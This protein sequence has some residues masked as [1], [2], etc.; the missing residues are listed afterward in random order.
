MNATAHGGKAVL[1][2]L[3]ECGRL[4]TGG[5]PNRGNSDYWGGDVPWIS[6]KS[7]KQFEVTDSEDR[8]TKAGAEDSTTLVPEGTILFV[9]RGMS[10]ANEFRV[11][12]TRRPV[13]FNQDLRALIPAKDIDARYLGRF[14]QASQKA[15]LGLTDE[16]SHGTKR[17]TSDRLAALQV[18]V[19]PLPEQR[20]IAALLDRAEALRAKRRAALAQLDT[21]TQAIFLEMFG[22]RNG[23]AN[24]T[25]VPLAD[26]AEVVSGITK[27]RKLNGRSARTVPYL[28][29]ANV[30]AGYLDLSEIKTIEAL[31]AEVEEL[32]LCPG[33]VVMTEGG[34]YDKLG[35]GAL[36][37]G[38]VAECVHQNHIFRVRT[39]PSR[40]LSRFFHDYLQT[41]AAR[42]YFLRCAKRTTNLAS[43][44]M[45]QLRA[46]PVPLPQLSLQ[47]EFARRVAAVELLKSRHRESLGK[48]DELFAS[49]Q[50]R[51]FRGEL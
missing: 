41:A 42:D 4:L 47:Q 36:W 23:R 19:P 32:R 49:L 33:D 28:R 37:E 16:A 21:L 44:N 27:G 20:R 50:H 15:V 7:L 29:V 48:L 10:L 30:Q 51:A 40:F 39:D 9:V 22:G 31:P 13:T 26:C 11:G 3:I 1:R 35:R 18:P 34:D 24:H 17:L 46:L 43:I 6:A 5:T 45:T 8:L 12:V 38:Q 14:L 25:T 2:P